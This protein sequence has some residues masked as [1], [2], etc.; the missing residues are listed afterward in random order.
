[1]EE[2]LLQDWGQLWLVSPDILGRFLLTRGVLGL[3]LTLADELVQGPP[4]RA[5]R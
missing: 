1:M 2:L 4:L 3:V 5:E